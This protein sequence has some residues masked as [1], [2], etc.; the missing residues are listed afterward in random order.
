MAETLC[1]SPYVHMSALPVIN[2]R[3]SPLILIYISLY[4]APEIL[5][6]EKYDAK[7]DLWSV[8]AVLYET[9]A[10]RAPFRA[11]NHIELLKKIEHSKGIKFPDE[12]PVALEKDP[13]LKTVPSDIKKLIRSLLKRFPA[14]RASFDEFFSSTALAKSKFPRPVAS[15][16]ASAS[17]VANGQ[18]MLG[19]SD[20][21]L[22]E[23]EAVIVG[24][25]QSRPPALLDSPFPESSRPAPSPPIAGVS[26]A[27]LVAAPKF[28]FRRR[29]NSTGIVTPSGAPRS[30]TD[31]PRGGRYACIKKLC[32]QS[33]NLMIY[34]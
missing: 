1:G 15:P 8:G 22:N 11:Q 5:R 17:P 13:E 32:M 28:N 24:T 31:S 21:I 7:A 34:V 20:Q 2:V 16:S 30:A 26:D 12:D 18:K 10:G 27:K 25:M 3:T 6:Y 19:R 23:Q 9:T 29:D 33:F 14:E 4:M